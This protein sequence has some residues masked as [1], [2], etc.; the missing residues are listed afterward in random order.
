MPIA[1][2]GKVYCHVD[3]RCA[4]IEAGDLLT[5]SDTPGRAMKVTDRSKAT[6]TVIGK[7]L[8]SLHAGLGTIPILV[9]LR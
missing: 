9:G 1:L 2:I 6:G 8:G 5:S 7:A 3:A 4:A